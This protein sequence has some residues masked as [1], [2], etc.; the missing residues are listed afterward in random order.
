MMDAKT[1]E[2]IAKILSFEVK[3]PEI[4]AKEIAERYPDIYSLAI[5]EYDE[6]SSLEHVGQR[7]AH[8][9]R[10][11]MSLKSRAGTDS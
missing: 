10:L 7:G 5:A 6:L 9:L 8:L 3:E 4:A 1:I 11:V 2:R